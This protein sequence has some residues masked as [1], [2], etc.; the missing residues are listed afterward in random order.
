MASN[1]IEIPEGVA[2]PTG[3]AGGDLSGSYPNPSIAVGAVTDTKASLANKPALAVVATTNQA[4][5]GLPT[6]DGVTVADGT[7]LLLSAQ[8]TGSQNGPWTAH[9]GAWTRP[10]WYPSGGTTQAF[11]FITTFI[12][13]GTT[14][15][16]TTWRQTA[17]GPITIDTTA[18]TW[19]VT[20]FALNTNTLTG[21]VP[22]ANGGTGVATTSQN[23][24]F[25]GPTSGSGAPSFRAA[26][27]ADAAPNTILSKSGSYV[28]TASDFAANTI[29]YANSSGG[30]FNLTFPSPSTVAVGKVLWVFDSTG[31]FGTNQVTMV[32]NGSENIQGLASNLILSANW[33]LYGFQTDGSNWFK[34]SQPSNLAT[35]TF[36]ASTT[37]TAP[38][39]VTA[40]RAFGRGGSGG[41]GSGG[42]GAGGS[43]TQ[44]GAG[45]GGGGSG[46]SAVSISI[47]LTVVSGTTYTITIGSGGSGAAGVS[48][49][50]A[51]P[52]GSVGVVGNPG[53]NGG[54]T[55]FGS[56][57]RFNGG[58]GGQNGGANATTFTTAG[59]G[60]AGGIMSWGPSGSAGTN[61]GVGGATGG[62]A[63]NGSAAV[64]PQSPFSTPSR[65]GTTGGAGGGTGGG[66]GGGAPGVCVGGDLGSTFG[67]T[68]VS[69]AGAAS[70]ANGTSGT[71]GGVNSGGIG[72]WASPGGSGGGALA[73]TGSQGGASLTA[74]DGNAGQ[75]VVTWYE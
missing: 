54:A 42:T 24:G 27:G 47:P 68:P 29:I 33:G 15:Q 10:S 36:A 20:P 11:Q 16:G 62:T 8:S 12:R 40:A 7:M 17:A 5:S 65:T 18:T 50:V 52:T 22:V 71:A 9:S 38:A 25:F 13:L 6:I 44:G 70:G 74:G 31:S 41:G 67:T 37:W 61:G 19:A 59:G 56:L 63:A 60:G 2:I 57:A 64:S 32:R 28:I 53:V 21:Q 30:A 34:V 43:T 72:G 58:V 48:A 14:Y 66:G 51:S 35:R 69:P 26:V 1:Y 49:G 75:M 39:G 4:L 46:G 45:G 73:G 55:L 3:P 23:F